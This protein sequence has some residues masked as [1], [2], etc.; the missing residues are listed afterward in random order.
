MLKPEDMAADS[1]LDGT[2]CK[3]AEHGAASP[4]VTGGPADVRTPDLP[5]L[6]LGIAPAPRATPAR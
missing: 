3:G 5:E 2:P 6:R 4:P 1:P